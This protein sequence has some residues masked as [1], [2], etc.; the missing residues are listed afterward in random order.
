MNSIRLSSQLFSAQRRFV[1][2]TPQVKKKKKSA[3]ITI[4]NLTAKIS[5]R[6]VTCGIN[7]VQ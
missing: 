2:I 7:Y 5:Q 3:K 4:S 6:A 1:M